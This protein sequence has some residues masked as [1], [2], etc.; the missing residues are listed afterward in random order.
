MEKVQ[1]ILTAGVDVRAVAEFSQDDLVLGF[2]SGLIQ[3][4]KINMTTLT[5]ATSSIYDFHHEE[6]I[7]VATTS[8]D[9]D[10]TFLAASKDNS[11]SFWRY[12]FRQPI[13]LFHFGCPIHH[14]ALYKNLKTEMEE[15]VIVMSN[16]TFAKLNF[17]YGGVFRG[18]LD[19]VLIDKW[20]TTLVKRQKVISK[21]KLDNK[22]AIIQAFDPLPRYLERTR[23]IK[24]SLNGVDRCKNTVSSLLP[25][26]HPPYSSNS[27]SQT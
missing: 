21:L 25:L 19:A 20:E 7:C 23:E 16:G 13:K 26:P 6:I 27:H 8:N 17:D 18:G 22:I 10:R 3:T 2:E 24:A 11:V 15:A 4:M 1:H 9:S 12:G 5:P 14:L